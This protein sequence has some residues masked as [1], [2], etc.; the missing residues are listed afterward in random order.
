MR[1]LIGVINSKPD[2][3]DGDH[4]KRLASLL[5]HLEEIA[6]NKVVLQVMGHDIDQKTTITRP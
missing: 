3:P 5:K 2:A 1:E 6:E 4:E